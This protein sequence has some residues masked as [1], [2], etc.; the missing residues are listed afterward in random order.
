MHG[1]FNLQYLINLASKIPP[2]TVYPLGRT[3][4]DLILTCVHRKI[5]PGGDVLCQRES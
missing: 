4:L 5:D 2:S 1:L 3:Q